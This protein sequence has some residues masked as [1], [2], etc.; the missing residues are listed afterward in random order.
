MEN[1]WLEATALG[2]D[3]HIVSSLASARLKKR[4]R[5]PG[6]PRAFKN[7]LHRASGY[8]AETPAPHL[9]VRREIEDFSHHNYFGT[10]VW[11]N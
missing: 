2:I 3:F 7:R 10:K 1:L 8:M 11:I 5:H 9:R 4:S 6:R